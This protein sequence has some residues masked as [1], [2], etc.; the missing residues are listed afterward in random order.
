MRDRLVCGLSYQQIQKRLLAEI[1]I[2]Q[3]GSHSSCY[4]NSHSRSTEIHSEFREGKTL[5]IY[6]LILSRSLNRLDSG[7]SSLV[8]YYPCGTNTHVATECRFKKDVCR[9]S[10]KGGHIQ[11]TCQAQQTKGPG[12][13]SLRYQK[14]THDFEKKADEQG[15]FL[16]NLDVNN[17]NKSS[18]DVIWVECMLKSTTIHATKHRNCRVHFSKFREKKLEKTT[19]VLETY[20][21]ELIVRVG[22]LTVQ[23]EYVDQPCLLA[24]HPPQMLAM[25]TLARLHKRS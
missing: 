2:P 1:K 16:N 7:P 8:E 24:V 14:S 6:K 17:V 10:G 11:R 22:C 3:S 25:K 15:H 20:T 12:R 13:H 21:G 23:V 5:D 4:G 18:S 19:T 9:K